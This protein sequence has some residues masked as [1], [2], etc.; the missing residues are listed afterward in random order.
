MR[1]IA[2][3]LVLLVSGAAMA[4]PPSL[5]EANEQTCAASWPERAEDFRNGLIAAKRY[6]REY[7]RAMPWFHEHCRVLSEI[8]IVVRKLDDEWSFVCD[9]QKGRPK[10]LTTEYVADHQSTPSPTMFVE[11]LNNDAWCE[12]FDAAA[13]RIVL[14]MPAR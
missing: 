6:K 8:E 13:G 14:R 9:T 10:G 3:L 4:Q 12:P 11:Y 1:T 5:S 2:V 7:E